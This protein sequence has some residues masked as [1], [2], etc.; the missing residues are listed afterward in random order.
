MQAILEDEDEGD[1]GGRASVVGTIICAGR[2]SRC[3]EGECNG[4][5]R[6]RR[7]RI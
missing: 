5:I 6:V 1:I 2:V 3:V 7:N 4:G